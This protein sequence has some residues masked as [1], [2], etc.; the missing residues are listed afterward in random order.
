MPQLL[1]RVIKNGEFRPNESVLNENPELAKPVASI[2]ALWASIEHSLSLLLTSM[3]GADAQ[4]AIAMFAT[5]RAKTLM[6]ATMLLPTLCFAQRSQQLPQPRQP[7]QWCGLDGERQLLRTGLRQG[8]D[9]YPQKWLVSGRLARERRLLHPLRVPPH[10]A[11]FWQRQTN[12]WRRVTSPRRG[13][14]LLT[15]SK[16]LT[17]SNVWS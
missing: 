13:A 15:P 14:K 11:Q 2:F 8:A 5:L 3:V 6:I 1:N 7:G 9:R 4:P 17:P 10:S 16:E 12:V